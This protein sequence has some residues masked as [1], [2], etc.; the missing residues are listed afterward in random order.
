MSARARENKKRRAAG[1]DPLPRANGSKEIEKVALKDLKK[2]SYFPT[3]YLPVARDKNDNEWYDKMDKAISKLQRR[4]Q[5]RWKSIYPTKRY[6]LVCEQGNKVVGKN[7]TK[8]DVQLYMINMSQE[9]KDAL[10]K[11][12]QEEIK[13]FKLE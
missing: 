1:L 8:L 2:S 5:S 10:D 3:Y 12:V 6:L 11:I 7:M 4:L 13:D 9:Y